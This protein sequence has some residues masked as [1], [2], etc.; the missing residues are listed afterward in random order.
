MPCFK[1]RIFPSR[2]TS[3]G[4]FNYR[5]LFKN[6]KL[7]FFPIVFWNFLWGEQGRDGGGQSRDR[8]HPPVSLPTRE[9]PAMRRRN[10]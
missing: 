4:I 7:L 8:E 2:F 6:N 1:A 9:N 10:L 5:L 3:G